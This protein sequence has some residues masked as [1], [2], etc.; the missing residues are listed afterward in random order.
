[1]SE[2]HDNEDMITGIN[3]TPLVDI[4]LVILIAFIIT[5]HTNV[6]QVIPMDLPQA[7]QS[8]DH[9]EILSVLIP[10]DGRILINGQEI[11]NDQAFIAMVQQ[12]RQDDDKLRAVINADGATPHNTVIHVLDLLKQSGVPQVAFGIQRPTTETP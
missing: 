8:D 1:M 4:T 3:I 12:L 5:A 7:S 11:A 10:S 2:E 6:Q 9:Q